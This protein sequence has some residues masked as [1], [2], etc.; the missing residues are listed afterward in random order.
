[1]QYAH[2]LIASAVRLLPGS[3][4]SLGGSL[5]AQVTVFTCPG[6]AVKIDDKTHAF[7][8][9]EVVN[10]RRRPRA[11]RLDKRSEHG[12][13]LRGNDKILVGF[14]IPFELAYRVDRE[15]DL[16]MAD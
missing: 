4:V 7:T 14:L 12:L 3:V 8:L 10:L 9:H 2:S 15:F 1:M 11:V 13:L 6:I 5:L 16:I